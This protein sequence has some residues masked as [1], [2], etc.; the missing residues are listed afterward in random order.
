VGAI[1]LGVGSPEWEV[2]LL[3]MVLF[4]PVAV[5]SY[6]RCRRLSRFPVWRSVATAYLAGNFWFLWVFTS[7]VNREQIAREWAAARAAEAAATT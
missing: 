6:R 3:Q 1:E 2:F 5:A 4:L 7:W